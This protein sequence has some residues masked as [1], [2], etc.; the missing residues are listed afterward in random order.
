MSST[1]RAYACSGVVAMPISSYSDQLSTNG[2]FMLR[3]PYLAGEVLTADTGAA[4][5]SAA[6]LSASQSVKMLYVQVQPGKRVHYE[7]TPKGHTARE[8][9]T[10]SPIMKDEQVLLFGEG[11]AISVLEAA[12]DA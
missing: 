8:A 6:P 1:V 5:A 11:W 9:T 12:A 7:I 2:Q 3:M 4:V 10:S